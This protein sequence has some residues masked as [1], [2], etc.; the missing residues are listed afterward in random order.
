M[1]APDR[2]PLDPGLFKEFRQELQTR[3]VAVIAT[4]TRDGQPEA[5]TVFYWANDF[6]GDGRDFNLYF[7]TRRS[8]RK[9]FC[10]TTNPSVAMVIGTEFAPMTIQ[11][12]G[13]AMPLEA[14]DSVRE[15]PAAM[16]LVKGRYGL[17]RLY[18]GELFP[19]NPFGAIPGHDFVV[20][21]VR[22]KWVRWMRYDKKKDL[23]EYHQVK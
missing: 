12:D 15:M 1:N 13:E 10:L 2:M 17:L 7:I 22:P 14:A 8:S 6:T 18:L 3:F 4:S 16:K 11:V 9:F 19:R 20:V 5:A 23:I 21:R